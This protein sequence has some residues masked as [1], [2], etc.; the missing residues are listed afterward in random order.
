MRKKTKRHRNP[1][2]KAM[3]VLGLG[4]RVVRNRKVYTR[5][6]RNHALQ[7]MQAGQSG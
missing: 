6:G 1:V 3:L 7:A 2:A 4:H 5:K